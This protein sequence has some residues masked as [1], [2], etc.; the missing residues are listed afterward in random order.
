MYLPKSELRNKDKKLLFAAVAFFIIVALVLAAVLIFKDE[1]SAIFSNNASSTAVEI[2]KYRSQLT[3]LPEKEESGIAP[4]IIAVMINNN[5]DGYPQVGLS[6]ASVIY[7]APAE[8]GITRFMAVYSA[9]SSVDKVGPVRSARTY[10][11][12]WLTEY[13]DALYM[14]CGGSP[15]GL[16]EIKKRG[17]FDANEF[18]RTK[19]FWRDDSRSAPYNLF[20]NGD[21]W[22]E[23]LVDYGENR[24]EKNWQGWLFGE[25]N[26]TG[27]EAVNKADI[28]Y[29]SN[30]I[31]SWQ[32]S[33]STSLYSRLVNDEKYLLDGNE[34]EVTNIIVQFAPVS[35][36]DEEGRVEIQTQSGGE[37]RLM[38][39]GQMVRGTW[40]KDS[41]GS[42]TRFYDPA[43]NELN[44]A[45]GR[46]WIMIAPLKTVITVSN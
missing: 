1:Y 29:A 20:T 5:R 18:S 3:G 25:M 23:Y 27:T 40:K 19:Y 10:F 39:D 37:I 43:G 2:Y 28:K 33:A 15:D 34:V 17:I 31:V 8:G 44:L 12:D 30:F 32:Y 4:K 41:L 35:V 46:S 16:I 22:R 14:H 45:P 36:V 42:R 6:D 13:G 38:R 9:S 21:R 24:A 11:L 26:A 7:E